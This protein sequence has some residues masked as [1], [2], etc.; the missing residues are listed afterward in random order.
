MKSYSGDGKSKKDFPTIII[1]PK[2]SRNQK[3]WQA[4]YEIEDR[5]TVFLKW[6]KIWKKIL[7]TT[8][9]NSGPSNWLQE[10]KY[11]SREDFGV[12][13]PKSRSSGNR[14]SSIF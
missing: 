10:R 11:L 2:S 6:K 7:K 3:S 9:A 8:Y 12:K 1:S 13:R 4:L 14:T 5:Q